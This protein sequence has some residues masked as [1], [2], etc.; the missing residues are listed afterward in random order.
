LEQHEKR[1]TKVAQSISRRSAHQ[2]QSGF[3]LPSGEL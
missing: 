3:P 2:N 1:Q